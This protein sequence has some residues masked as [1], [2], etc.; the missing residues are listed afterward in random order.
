MPTSSREPATA[1]T[2]TAIATRGARRLRVL[3]LDI[4]G[5]HGGSSRSLHG[6]L[7]AIDRTRVE[8]EVWCR[9]PGGLSFYTRI[10]VPCR[11][12]PELPRFSAGSYR[13]R[14][15]LSQLRR[16]IPGFLRARSLVW[17]LAETIE[18]CF[19]VVHFNHTAFFLLARWLRRYTRKAFVMHLRTQTPNSFLGRWQARTIQ[20]TMTGCVFI[21]ENE[22]SHHASLCPSLR[23]QVIYNPFVDAAVEPL[24]SELMPDVRGRTV[25][26]SLGN[27]SW[28]R[29]IDRLIDVARVLKKRERRDILFA[30]A[31]DMR[32]SATLP[33]ILG[34]VGARGGTLADVAAHYGVEDAFT[35]LGHISAPER[36]IVASRAVVTLTREA[37]PWGRAVI[38]ALGLGRPVLG[39]G[40]WSRFIEHG[41]TGFLY[42]HFDA[43]QVASDIIRLADEPAYA[44]TLGA[45]GRTRIL[46]L[47]NASDRAADLLGVWEKAAE[48]ET[49]SVSH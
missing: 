39:I 24:P 6:V 14:D 38:E 30:V 3:C 16:S 45:Q 26:A 33:G 20:R 47:C 28:Y 49:A 8:P 21:T 23:G 7:A 43:K 18:H 27:Y 34:E 15:N 41:A 12:E 9:S 29:G 36:L 32:L 25:I 13:L 22:A 11:V 44:A 48:S 5:G 35:F 37:N 2:G 31:G 42:P 19:D 4:E 46:Q 40:T 17:R 1:G 10:G